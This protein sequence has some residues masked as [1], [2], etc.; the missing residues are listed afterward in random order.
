MKIA[1]PRI[2]VGGFLHETHSFAPRPTRLADF[3]QPA[4]FPWL[5]RGPGLLEAL[6]DHGAQEPLTRNRAAER[7]GSWSEN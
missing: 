2:A 7:P 4:G 6:R 1:P 3:R 5:Q